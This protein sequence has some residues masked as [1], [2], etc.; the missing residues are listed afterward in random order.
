[1][2]YAA[3]HVECAASCPKQTMGN[4]HCQLREGAHTS[5]VRRRTNRCLTF[6]NVR[7]GSISVMATAMVL[8]VPRAAAYGQLQVLA[9]LPSEERLGTS[10]THIARVRAKG[11]SNYLWQ[12]VSRICIP[13]TTASTNPTTTHRVERGWLCPRIKTL[14][15]SI[16]QYPVPTLLPGREK[17]FEL[18]SGPGYSM[19]DTNRYLPSM[20]ALKKC[21]AH[22]RIFGPLI[23]RILLFE[24]SLFLGHERSTRIVLFLTVL[25]MYGNK[26]IRGLAHLESPPWAILWFC[27]HLLLIVQY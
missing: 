13:Q 14:C 1:V 7:P 12:Y 8:T 4:C 26:Y 17:H 9:L 20:Y 21:N 11:T 24:R 25:K 3:E 5:V 16:E 23:P 6:S 15:R 27:A 18:R 10:P 19:A 22:T 2:V